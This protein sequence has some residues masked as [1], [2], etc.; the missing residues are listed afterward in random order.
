M[1]KFG[2]PK[3]SNYDACISRCETQDAKLEISNN[4]I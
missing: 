3:I 2:D 1:Y 4:E